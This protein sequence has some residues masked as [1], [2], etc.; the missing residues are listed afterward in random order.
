MTKIICALLVAIYTG[1][2]AIAQ[3]PEFI[4]ITEKHTI[5]VDKFDATTL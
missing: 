5:Y 1:G 3:T 2:N 4:C